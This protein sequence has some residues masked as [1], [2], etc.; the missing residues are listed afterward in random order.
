MTIGFGS[1]TQ[2]YS[3]NYTRFFTR[4]FQSATLI[5]LESPYGKNDGI[6]WDSRGFTNIAGPTATAA[7]PR[8]ELVGIH[9]QHHR[10]QAA[11]RSNFTGAS[12]R[13]WLDSRGH[14]ISRM[15]SFLGGESQCTVANSPK[16]GNQYTNC[17]T[18]NT[19]K[20]ALKLN[21]DRISKTLQSHSPFV[22]PFCSSLPSRLQPSASTTLH[23]FHSPPW[24]GRRTKSVKGSNQLRGMVGAHQKTYSV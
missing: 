23:D 5:P 7:V 2:L 9:W 8:S 24:W 17:R 10:V 13:W 15:P 19:P 3:I 1:T 14:E 4:F 6:Y 16:S 12:H 20:F 18:P 22:S 21:C 11:W